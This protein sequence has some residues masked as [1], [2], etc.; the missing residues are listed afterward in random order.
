MAALT[1]GLLPAD[2]KG[3]YDIMYSPD[4]K[5]EAGKVVKQLAPHM[6]AVEEV[7]GQEFLPII[8][9]S[10]I[11]NIFNQKQMPFNLS[12]LRDVLENADFPTPLTPNKIGNIAFH[13]LQAKA[14]EYR[15]LHVSVGKS[16]LVVL[17]DPSDPKILGHEIVGHGNQE[18]AKDGNLHSSVL[19]VPDVSKPQISL[20][21]FDKISDPDQLF[22]LTNYREN[23]ADV[24]DMLTRAQRGEG[25]K[26]M[27]AENLLQSTILFRKVLYNNPQ[28][29]DYQVTEHNTYRSLAA[30][31]TFLSHVKEKD[32]PKVARAL[33]TIQEKYN[34]MTAL[35]VLIPVDNPIFPGRVI[36]DKL[37]E[38]G[39]I[40]NLSPQ[41]TAHLA[42]GF[43]CMYSL[44]PQ[45]GKDFNAAALGDE[46][47]VGA[48]RGAWLQVG[49]MLN[50]P[51]L[52]NDP[53]M[54]EL[55]NDPAYQQVTSARESIEPPARKPRGHKVS[56]SSK[57]TPQ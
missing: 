44:N 52:K 42:A 19:K 25:I 21:A 32:W 10:K 2:A 1:V 12:N 30:T 46:A 23:M 43:A 9:G 6:A 29:L 28:A 26:G 11:D 5:S 53:E 17:F 34:E 45:E 55:R 54:Q 50:N 4:P 15:A 20:K 37:Q 38:E 33:Y 16:H 41:E 48:A 40:K 35:D 39:D 56:S 8:D 22:L 49:R 18:Y 24:A 3:G 47:P 7:T 14:L 57:Y 51:V 27:A 13:I 31:E 36:M